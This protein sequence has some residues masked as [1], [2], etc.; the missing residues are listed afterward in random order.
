MPLKTAVIVNITSYNIANLK[1]KTYTITNSV[2]HRSWNS[3]EKIFRKDLSTHE[4]L[5]FFHVKL[6]R[7][8]I[9]P[10]GNQIFGFI[11]SMLT[12]QIL[13][14]SAS[15][16]VTWYY[17]VPVDVCFGSFFLIAICNFQ[18]KWQILYL[19]QPLKVPVYSNCGKR[20]ALSG[21]FRLS[22]RFNKKIT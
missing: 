8:T 2:L 13:N 19:W 14:S 10:S 3:Y 16:T 17:C 20:I 21:K 18:P 9:L 6:A 5:F 12:S 11:S 7:W 4:K 1:K 22:G 15:A